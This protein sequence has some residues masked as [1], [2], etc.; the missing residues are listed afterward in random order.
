MILSFSESN[1]HDD[2]SQEQD[3]QDSRSTNASDGQ[4]D[5]QDVQ[6]DHDEDEITSSGCGFCFL[7]PCVTSVHRHWLG[8]GQPPHKNNPGL[9]KER[10]KKYWRVI[11]N[12]G[13]WNHPRYIHRKAMAENDEDDG[14]Q[15]WNK[16]EI[17]PECVLKQVRGLYPN[18]PGQP[19]MGHKWN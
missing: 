12:C 5:G 1:Q 3:L 16:R 19:Y 17:M 2:T 9:R 15:V 11:A 14:M 18:P 7:E 6:P 4:D 8:D 10:Y 13:G